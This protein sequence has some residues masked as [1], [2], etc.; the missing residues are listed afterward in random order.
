MVY[1]APHAIS[2]SKNEILPYKYPNKLYELYNYDI[3]K[4]FMKYYVTKFLNYSYTSNIV[5]HDYI[6]IPYH[7]E[8]ES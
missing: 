7:K 6:F 8:R 2:S 3:N 5:F 4:V 1:L